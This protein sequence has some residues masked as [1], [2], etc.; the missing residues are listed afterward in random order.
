[1]Y[2]EL[3]MF[4][5]IISIEKFLIY[6]GQLINLYAV[7]S[8]GQSAWLRTKRSEVRIPYGV[9]FIWVCSKS[10]MHLQLYKKYADVAKLVSHLTFNQEC[11]AHRRFESSHP[12]QRC[13]RINS[14]TLKVNQTHYPR[15]SGLCWWCY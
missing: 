14:F 9:P 7:S 12:H 1:M 6:G 4:L 11:L 8:V 5:I 13:I 3:K 10:A 15:L 2:E